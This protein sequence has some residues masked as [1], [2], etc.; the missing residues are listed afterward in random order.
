[1]SNRIEAAVAELVD[2]LR[3]ESSPPDTDPPRLLSIAEAG[4]ALGVGRSLLYNELSAG[5]LRSVKV[6]KRR[7]VPANA[8]REYVGR[9]GQTA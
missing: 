5:R 6:G 3:A 8:V 4:Q 7:L 2:A 1:M 9:A